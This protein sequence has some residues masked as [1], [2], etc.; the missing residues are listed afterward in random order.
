[1][2]K[3]HAV[4]E[5]PAEWH[6]PI[7]QYYMLRGYKVWVIEPFH[8]YH[9]QKCKHAFFP[10]PEFPKYIYSL[11]KA[12]KLSLLPSKALSPI[13]M[14]AIAMEKAV[15]KVEKI[16]SS[17]GKRFD[18]II[19]LTSKVL[20][21][22]LAVNIF[23]KRLCDR[24]AVFYSTDIMLGRIQGFLSGDRIVVYP[25]MN[26]HI[27]SDYRKMIAS[28]GEAVSSYN[29]LRLSP[30]LYLMGLADVLHD[31]IIASAKV[32]GMVMLSFLSLFRKI[33][34]AKQSRT[35]RFGIAIVAPSRQLRDNQR[36]ADFLVDGTK[37]TKA[38]TVFFPILPLTGQQKVEAAKLNGDIYNLPAAERYFA[39]FMNWMTLFLVSLINRPFRNADVVNEASRAFVHF[40]K[41]KRVT[42]EIDIEN[43]ITHCDFG[44]SHIARNIALNQA[45][46]KTWYF[47]DSMNNGGVYADENKG[48]EGLHPF[49]PYMNYDR[50]VTWDEMI[51]RYF[52]RHPGH[53]RKADVVGCLWSDHISRN[54]TKANGTD[55]KFV[56]SVFDSTYS[57]NSFTSYQEGIVFATHILRLADELPEITIHFKEKKER[58]IHVRYLDPILGPELLG[59]YKQMDSHP[60][61]RTYNNQSDSSELISGSDLIISFPFTSITFEALAAGRPAV[62]H[63]PEGNYKNTPYGK[64]QGVTTNGYDELISKVKEIIVLKPGE[65]QNPIG[66]RLPLMDPFRDGRAIDRFRDLLIGFKEGGNQ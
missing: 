34:Q 35:Y 57:R 63:D 37:I 11:L 54:V 9:H 42:E 44:N 61:I 58:D 1:M 22:D 33:P 59:L 4:F 45:G 40:F 19:G 51:S 29:T 50:F 55:N 26:I 36:R 56:V 31:N 10:D 25:E 24:L 30:V 41:W 66:E 23:K 18:R 8:A 20:D 38:D 52:M 3:R 39:N 2:R 17:Y 60:G 16:F 65:F 47:S 32:F 62:W 27:Y 15:N 43:F 28:S 48:I 21:S 13:D 53:F 7:M 12:N 5:S 49:W 14:S 6:K 46:V 64:I